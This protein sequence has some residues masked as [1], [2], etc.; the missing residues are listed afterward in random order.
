MIHYEVNALNPASHLFNI[1]MTLP[2]GKGKQTVCLPNWIPGSYLIRDYPRHI[3]S[4]Q[5]YAFNNGNM[6]KIALQKIN[7]NTWVCE[8][9]DESIV[10]EYTV[11]AWDTSV[12]GAHLDENHAFFNPCCLFLQLCSQDLPCQVTINPPDCLGADKWRVATTMTPLDAAP[13]GYGR[14]QAASYD[15]LIDHPVEIGNFDVVEFTVA[16]IPHA[17]V[18][19]G[20]HDGDLQ[21]L[22]K[23]VEKICLTHCQLFNNERPFSRY[24]FLLNILKE[25][26]GGLEHRS[27]TALLASREMLPLVND[28]SISRQYIN[29]LA[30]FSHEYFHAWNIKSIKPE[31]FMPYNLNEKCYTKQLWAF[32]G[33]TSYYDELALLRAKVITFDQYL[34]L[35][36]QT[37]T[38]VLRTPGSFV[39]TLADASFDAWIK[40]YQPN[41][42]SPNTQASYYLKGSLV[43]LAFDL[44]LRSTTQNEKSL[45]K[46]MNM[47]WQKYGKPLIGVP[48]GKIESL[49]VQ[50]GGVQM[51][52]L[53]QDAI[54]TTKVLPMDTLL[55]PFGLK[56]TLRPQLGA[57]DMGGKKLNYENTFKP[58]I[59]QFTLTKSQSRL[60]VSTLVE[61]GAAMQAGISATDEIV[62]LNGL[63]IDSESF[64]KISKRL[65]AG[66]KV[67][68]HYFRQDI[69]KETTVTLAAPPFDTA[70]ITLMENRSEEQKRNLQAWLQVDKV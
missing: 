69:L 39:Q 22:A 50:E 10:L 62:A 66:Q 17:I 21:R 13:W 53:V 29:L 23:D 47:L 5:A 9:C 12:R 33:I 42:N 43:A 57:D 18:V 26:Y 24:L 55:A 41:E 19:S 56:V 63:R 1:R 52:L 46:I 67:K 34:D 25:G 40:F 8:E 20:K 32:E 6:T 3:V 4:I 58:G 60:L 64:D 48:E 7:S 38:K 14:Y 44:T 36:A 16:Q 51:A 54:Y 59:F 35:L 11:Y 65:S 45:D 27:C 61:N 28:P 30:L 2:K 15:E 49:I 70:Q 31:S 68:V 37:L